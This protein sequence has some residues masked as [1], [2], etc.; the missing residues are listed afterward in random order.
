MSDGFKSAASDAMGEITQAVVK[1]VVAE[2]G[3]VIEVAGQSI[4]GSNQTNP[5][6]QKKLQEQNAKKLQDQVK[7]QKIRAWINNYAEEERKLKFKKV[8][9]AQQKQ[10]EEQV[11]TQQTQVKKVEK[12]KKQ[13]AMQEHIQRIKAKTEIKGGAGG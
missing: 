1:P 12:V 10:Q 13:N 8:Q 7:A 9:V 6:D 5:Q 4:T 11:E 2:A 3:Q